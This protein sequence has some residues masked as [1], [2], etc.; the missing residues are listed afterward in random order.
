MKGPAMG[1]EILEEGLPYMC[2]SGDLRGVVEE[3]RRAA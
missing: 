3:L 1:R 2:V